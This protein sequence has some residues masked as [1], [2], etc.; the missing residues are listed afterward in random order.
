MYALKSFRRV[1]IVDEF[2]VQWEKVITT[3]NITAT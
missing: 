2:R 3:N 1:K